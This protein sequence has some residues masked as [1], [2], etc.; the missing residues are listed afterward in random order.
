MRRVTEMFFRN[1]LVALVDN[2]ENIRSTCIVV[3]S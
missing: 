3:Y 1:N 2:N